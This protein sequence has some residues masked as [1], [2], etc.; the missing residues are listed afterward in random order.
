M[1]KREDSVNKG[2]IGMVKGSVSE[3]ERRLS[4]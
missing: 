2:G 3:E 1:R 4:G